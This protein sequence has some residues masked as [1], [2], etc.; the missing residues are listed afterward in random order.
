MLLAS[1]LGTGPGG[2]LTF[3]SLF[4]WKAVA[5]AVLSGWTCWFYVTGFNRSF[6]LKD[7]KLFTS[8]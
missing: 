6:V 8:D 3:A 7:Q 1:L 2:N 4:L 5:A